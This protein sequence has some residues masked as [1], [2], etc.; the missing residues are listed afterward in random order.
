MDAERLKSFVAPV[1]GMDGTV[2]GTGV[3]VAPDGWFVTSGRCGDPG[4]DLLVG[5]QP[6]L[7]HQ[8]P[9]AL[10][11]MLFL[12][13]R[14]PASPAATF[15]DGGTL[16]ADLI[17]IAY[18]GIDDRPRVYSVQ[19]RTLLGVEPIMLHVELADGSGFEHGFA[20]A[21][22]F[23][24]RTSSLVG[25]IA[26]VRTDRALAVPARE[27]QA[28]LSTGAAHQKNAVG[29]RLKVFISYRG[30]KPD[31][32]LAQTFYDELVARRFDAFLAGENIR[33][34][35]EWPVRVN[36]ELESCD[37]FLLLLSPSAARSEMV[38]E[39][40]RH[41]KRLQDTRSDRR[42]LILPIRVNLPMSETLTYDLSGY[43]S[44]IQ[45]EEWTSHADT[46]L[47]IEKL[48]TSVLARQVRDEGGQTSAPVP[49]A[50]LEFPEGQV[51]I[52]SK[53]Y[54]KRPPA[55]ETCFASIL[56]PGALIRIKA[57]RQM[58]KTSLMARIL[59]HAAESGYRSVPLTFQ[60]ADNSI[61]ADR[62]K[63][64]RWFCSVVSWRAEVEDL[65][66]TTWA[67]APGSKMACTQYFEEYLL[68]VVDQPLAIGLDEV[69]LVFDE[70]RVAAD[71][72][73][74]L[75]GW[76]EL[77]KSHDIWKKL[78]LILAHSTEVY[79]PLKI[80]ESPF[81]V[82]Q[83][84]TLRDFNEQQVRT[85]VGRHG[86]SWDSDAVQ[87]LMAVV[88]GH[89]FLIRVALYHIAH[90]DSVLN[91]DFLAQSSTDSGFYGDHLRRHLWNLEQNPQ[92]AQAMRAVVANHEPVQLATE[93]AFKLDSTGLVTRQG[94]SVS[95]RCELYRQYFAAH[96]KKTS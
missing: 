1:H 34:G 53:F 83:P 52:E 59:C 71:F 74:L 46:A 12:S 10:R 21:P 45:Q 18:S 24:P 9:T 3:F 49:L 81:N 75:R 41:A 82:G 73:S 2:R 65:T 72:F 69:D 96:L 54:I 93:I 35:E 61:F 14:A 13:V 47:L 40:V 48:Y 43:L 92:L 91:E 63:L 33:W 42:P 95:V 58:G 44:R 22:I 84:I 55:E 19:A 64:L 50:A 68:K 78:R 90:G 39:E 76:H 79:I 16:P 28:A 70:P 87:G 23:D 67:K 36:A 89:P 94:N 11:D 25:V 85:L 6:T 56:Q 62:D 8:L 20:G 51:D 37:V 27:I 77:G 80:N 38:I 17:A 15:T 60:L 26:E 88:G 4:C 66:A 31:A 32:A 29:K 5:G 30:H 86:L 57:P 7:V